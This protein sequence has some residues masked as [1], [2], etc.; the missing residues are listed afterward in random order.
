M[1]FPVEGVR[2]GSGRALSSSSPLMMSG[3]LGLQRESPERMISTLIRVFFFSTRWSVRI[4][5]GGGRREKVGRGRGGGVCVVER[6]A[7]RG[8]VGVS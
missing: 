8:A 7:E 4:M 6:G 5:G 3:F 2:A 1:K